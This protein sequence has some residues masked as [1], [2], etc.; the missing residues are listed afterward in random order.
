MRTSGGKQKQFGAVNQG[1]KPGCG[2][3]YTLYPC[4]GCRSYP[5]AVRLQNNKG[6]DDYTGA[7]SNLKNR[8]TF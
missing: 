3:G 6:A 7:G 1:A 8:A 2:S 4:A 5:A